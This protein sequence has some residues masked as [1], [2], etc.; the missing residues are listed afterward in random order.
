MRL[1]TRIS[2]LRDE[3]VWVPIRLKL[4]FRYVEVESEAKAT[5]SLSRIEIILN[6]FTQKSLLL[7][8]FLKSTE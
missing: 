6:L 4:C 1:E 8:M 2:N 5:V 7:A 3:N